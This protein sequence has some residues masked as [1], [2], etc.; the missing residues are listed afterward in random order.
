MTRHFD[1][2]ARKR[3][4]DG[5]EFG[6]DAFEDYWRMAQYTDGCDAADIRDRVV[7]ARAEKDG[8]RSSE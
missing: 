4:E 1:L 3:I 6:R 7:A 2:D 5:A 8:V